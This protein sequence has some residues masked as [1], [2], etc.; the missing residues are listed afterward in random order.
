MFTQHDCTKLMSQ[1]SNKEKQRIQEICEELKEIFAA[2]R[3]NIY[4]E[5]SY[6][7]VSEGLLINYYIEIVDCSREYTDKD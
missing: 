6:K 2:Q 7:E 5:S 3:V 4:G 1:F